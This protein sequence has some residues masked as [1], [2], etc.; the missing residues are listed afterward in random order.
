MRQPAD[1]G[2]AKQHQPSAS[3]ISASYAPCWRPLDLQHEGERTIPLNYERPRL[4]ESDQPRAPRR[5]A[6]RHA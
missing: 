3:A 2:S 4:L 6:P 5:V 1:A